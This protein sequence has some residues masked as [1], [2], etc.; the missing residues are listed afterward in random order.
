MSE[1]AYAILR[2]WGLRNERPRTWADGERPIAIGCPSRWG[3]A[4]TL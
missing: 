1:A 2:P 4:A 3:K